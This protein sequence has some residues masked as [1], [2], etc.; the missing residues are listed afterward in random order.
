MNKWK[1]KW[2][3]EIDQNIPALSE[4]IKNAQIGVDEQ[5]TRTEEKAFRK[6]IFFAGLCQFGRPYKQQR[7]SFRI[8]KRENAGNGR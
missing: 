3:E 5:K 1:R 6:K 8:H 4:F 2:K 7:P